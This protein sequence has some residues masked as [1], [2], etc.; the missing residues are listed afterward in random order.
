MPPLAFKPESFHSLSAQLLMDE[1][2]MILPLQRLFDDLPNVVFFLK[3]R[4]GHYLAVNRTLVE[5]CGFTDKAEVLGRR[6][7]ELFPAPLA[8]RYARQD[9][10]VVQSGKAVLDQLELHLYPNRRCGWCLTNKYP[11]PDAKTGS[12]V[13]VAGISR[14]VES[15]SAARGFPEL[16]RALDAIQQRLDDPPGAEELARLCQLSPAKFARLVHRVFGL[17]PRQL[18][19]KA[20]LDEALHLL[21]ATGASLSDI[22]LRTGFCDQ[23]AFTRHFRRLAGLPPGVFRAQIAGESA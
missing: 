10:Q 5:R 9:A 8:A 11:I 22:A 3:D 6:P 23:S 14:D 1:A 21:A 15:S 13:A 16:A 18:A 17:T 19:L 7:S 20:R 4:I 2:T 12:V